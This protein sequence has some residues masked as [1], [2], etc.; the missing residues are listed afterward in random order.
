MDPKQPEQPEAD[1]V[2]IEDARRR[3]AAA[4]SGAP[5][6]APP[7][8]LPPGAVTFLR[9]V[10]EAIAR[11]LAGV[12][13]PEGTARAGG[14][15]EASRAKTAAVLKGLGLGLGQALAEAFGKW[16]QRIESGEAP[17][18]GA[19]PATGDEPPPEKTPS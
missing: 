15:D 8:Q 14:S 10:M 12:P 13:D 19:A 9:P 6:D 7:P 3:A 16:A 1:V 11:E 2:S 18:P 17:L 4:D 5:T